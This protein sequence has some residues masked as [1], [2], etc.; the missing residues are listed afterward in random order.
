M[1]DKNVGEVRVLVKLGKML[2]NETQDS[3]EK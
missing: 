2:D 1:D 3:T